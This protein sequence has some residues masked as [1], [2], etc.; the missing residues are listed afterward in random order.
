MITEDMLDKANE[1]FAQLPE[2]NMILFNADG[3]TELRYS[4]KFVTRNQI[5]EHY[6]QAKESPKIFDKECSDRLIETFL[7]FPENIQRIVNDI[8]PYHVMYQQDSIPYMITSYQ[9]IACA[10]GLKECLVLSQNVANCSVEEIARAYAKKKK[11]VIGG[12]DTWALMDIF[13][14]GYNC[15]KGQ[16]EEMSFKF[17]EWIADNHWQRNIKGE[18]YDKYLVAHHDMTTEKLYKIYLESKK[19]V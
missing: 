11:L 15:S 12:I 4:D 14:D 6:N 9:R 13:T 19:V 16:S 7:T 3:G 2:I 8:Y 10:M 17:A 1:L 18:W 5:V